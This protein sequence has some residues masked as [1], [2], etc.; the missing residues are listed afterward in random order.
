MAE[1]S[2]DRPKDGQKIALVTGAAPGGIGGALAEQLHA[3]GYFVV[4]AVRRPS[5]SASLVRPGI[6]LV[7]LDVSKTASVEAA[8]HIVSH[9]AGGRLDVLVNNAGAAHHRPVLDVDVD[10]AAA[11][12]FNVNVLGPMRMTKAFANLLIEA[13]GLIV[14]IGSVAP[15]A[16]MVYSSAYNMTKAALHSYGDSLAME[17]EPFG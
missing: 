14:N 13:K 5:A 11:D 6:I 1:L 10:G 4:C 9:T 12:M 2:S 8:A 17:M 16:P 15:I 3:A 7:E